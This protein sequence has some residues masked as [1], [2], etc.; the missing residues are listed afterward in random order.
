MLPLKKTQYVDCIYRITHKWLFFFIFYIY[1]FFPTIRI[2]VK[3]YCQEIHTFWFSKPFT[4]KFC[5]SSHNQFL[6]S[7][8]NLL[9]Q[10]KQK[11]IDCNL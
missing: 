8:P 3:E 5:V 11:I 1:F 4:L 7:I 6:E 10:I 9:E 2:T